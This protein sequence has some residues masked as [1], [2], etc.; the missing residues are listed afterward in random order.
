MALN[1]ELNI[2]LDTI[3]GDKG[4]S[5]AEAAFEQ[6]LSDLDLRHSHCTS[7]LEYTY[8]TSLVERHI[9]DFGNCSMVLAMSLRPCLMS[10]LLTLALKRPEKARPT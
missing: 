2:P 9:G 1:L 8:L 6:A 4:I 3:F 10:A 5:V 7:R